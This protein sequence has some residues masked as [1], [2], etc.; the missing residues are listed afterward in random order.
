MHLAAAKLYH[1]QCHEA[2]HRE[3]QDLGP[4]GRSLSWWPGNPT[5]QSGGGD[6][7]TWLNTHPSLPKEGA[8]FEPIYKLLNPKSKDENG[9]PVLIGTLKSGVV[10]RQYPQLRCY[11]LAIVL[12]P[13]LL[14]SRWSLAPPVSLSAVLARS[15]HLFLR[16]VV[17]GSFGLRGRLFPMAVLRGCAPCARSPLASRYR[18]PAP[19]A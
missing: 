11:Q 1:F 2:H 10:G 8:N 17:P 4:H 7:G 5:M 16:L 18:L 15:A 3:G 9:N 13:P 14:L 12:L 19:A 6:G